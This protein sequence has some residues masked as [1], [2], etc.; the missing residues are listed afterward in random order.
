[1]PQLFG[2][3]EEFDNIFDDLGDSQKKDET[4]KNLHKILKPFLL[5]R[6]KIEVEKALLPKK[7]NICILWNVRVTENMVKKRFKK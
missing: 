4:I 3:A 6:I 2:E 7:G 1:M 5:R